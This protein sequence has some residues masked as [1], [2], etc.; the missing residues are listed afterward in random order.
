MS[1]EKGLN[2]NLI[3]A[4]IINTTIV[5]EVNLMGEL[6]NCPECNQLFVKSNLRDVC[7]SCYKIEVK[8][9]DLVYT[10]IRKR[11]NRTATIPEI[12]DA[13]DVDEQKI[14]KW[15]RIGKLRVADYPNLGYPCERCGS[16]IKKGNIC[17]DCSISIKRDLRKEEAERE[18]IK[19]LRKRDKA[20]YLFDGKK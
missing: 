10:F 18:R 9:F 15:I 8:E 17:E 16:L 20:T 4:D 1:C 6:M 19:E 11:E 5:I 14:M 3:F 13:T 7:E 12:V 2:L